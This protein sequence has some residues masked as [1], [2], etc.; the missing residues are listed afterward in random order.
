MPKKEKTFSAGEVI[1]KQGEPC[2]TVYTILDG[3][4]ELYYEVN[5]RPRVL[6]RKGEDDQLGADAVLEGAYATSARAVTALTVSM[7]TADEY[8]AQLQR[9]GE[10]SPAAKPKAK[11]SDSFDTDDD[12]DDGFNFSFGDDDEE[13]EEKPKLPVRAGRRKSVI[14]SPRHGNVREEEETEEKTEGKNASALVKVEKPLPIVAAVQKP[15][16]LPAEIKKFPIKEWLREGTEESVAFGPVVLLASVDRDSSGDIRDVLYQTLR[17]IPNLQVKAVDKSITDSNIRRGAMQM[18]SWMEQ[19]NAD[20]GLY[21]VLDNAGRILEFHTVRP[22]NQTDMSLFS[23]GSRFFLP[24]Q[25]SDEQKTLLKIF[26]ICAMTPTRLE[27]EQLLR[28]FLPSLLNGIIAYA[29]EPMTGLTGEE[30]AVNLT[31]FANVLSWTSLIL[32]DAN[33]QHQAMEL[34]D[35][36]LKTLPSYAPEYVFVNRQVGLLRQMEAEKNDNVETFRAAEEIFKKGLEA[37]SEK[38]QPEAY[39]DLKQRIGSVRQK[40]ALQTGEGE[41][42]AQAMSA[43]RDALKSLSPYQ[44]TERWADAISGLARTMQLFSSYS[45]KTTLL[46]KAVELY[47]KELDVLDKDEQPMLWGR[48]CN[49]LASALFLLSDREGG[50]PDLLR[51]AVEVFSDALQIY[52]RAGAKE[53]AVVADN[54]L[55]R[56]EKILKKT[57]QELEKNENWLNDILKNSS[58]KQEENASVSDDQPLTFERIAVFEELDDEDD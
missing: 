19:H 32:S 27:H 1:F 33:R 18:Q 11:V 9:S 28:L 8:I 2:Q 51:R 54:N 6:G 37:V 15:V 43:Y 7:Q 38:H 58:E 23:A 39:S 46:K 4:A 14:S 17:Q 57:E 45:T 53:M 25:M 3:K 40:I 48:A 12:D 21:A 31:A 5:G 26:T 29:S 22:A 13:E 20:V 10:L 42:F 55:K 41:D 34:Y 47:E 36:A 30:Q 16:V 44:H 50:K 52:D 24:V 56:A 35:K 49:N